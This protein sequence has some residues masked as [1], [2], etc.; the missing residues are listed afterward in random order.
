[1]CSIAAQPLA[2][3]VTDRTRQPSRPGVVLQQALATTKLR[4]PDARE[5]FVVAA[6]RGQQPQ[7]DRRRGG[8]GHTRFAPRERQHHQQIADRRCQQEAVDNDGLA[9]TKNRTTFWTGSSKRPAHRDDEFPECVSGGGRSSRCARAGDVSEPVVIDVGGASHLPPASGAVLA[10]VP[11]QRGAPA[12]GGCHARGAARRAE[13]FAHIDA[14][15]ARLCVCM[16]V[17]GPRAWRAAARAPA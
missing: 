5:D 2:E 17:S 14:L 9:D 7:G 15:A 11:L 6:D 12:R 4:D 10:D 16:W 1:M 3:R 8:A 13:A